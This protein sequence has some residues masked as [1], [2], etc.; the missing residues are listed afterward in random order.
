MFAKSLVIGS[1]LAATLAL[2]ATG[3]AQVTS[4]WTGAF[5]NEVGIA[6]NWT[7]ILPGPTNDVMR[8]DGT[9]SGTLFLVYA[10][11]TLG[12]AAGNVGLN[13]LLASTQTDAVNI[14]SGTTASFRLNNIAVAGGAGALT[15][16]GGGSTFNITSGGGAGT[17]FWTN[18]S[19]NAVT[20]GANIVLGTGSAAARDIFLGGS[21]NF[22]FSNSFTLSNAGS[23]GVIKDGSGT[24]TL[25]H[26]N[27]F[28]RRSLTVLGGT[29][30]LSGM[31]TN[32]NVGA[33][34]IA[35]IVGTNSGAIPVFNLN[36]GT[37]SLIAGNSSSVLIGNNMANSQ[38][39][40]NQNGGLVRL[41]GSLF[42]GQAAASTNNYAF[43]NMNGGEFNLTGVN[44]FR[45]G[46][47][48]GTGSVALLYLNAGSMSSG[49][50]VALND[51]AGGTA[52]FGGAAGLYVPAG[53]LTVT[54]ATQPMGI[55][56]RQGRSEV[57]IAGSGYVNVTTNTILGGS[58]A[59]TPAAGD[60]GRVAVLNLGAGS[61]GGTL[62]TRG[63]SQDAN[64]SPLG[65]LN[66]HGGT[67]KAQ[68]D[69]P[70]FITGLT[71]ATI[72][73]GGAKIDDNGFAVTIPQP[74]TAPAGSG[75]VSIAV[76]GASGYTGAPYVQLTGG[77]A[78]TPATAVALLNS[79]G[80]VT[81]VVVTA[82]GTGYTGAPT[83]TL[84]G[85]GGTYTS[86]TATI[87]ANTSG[88]LTK[89][90]S[91][92]LTL[93]GTNTYTG[94]TFVNTG[95]L[96][97]SNAILTGLATIDAG[98][99]LSG[100]GTINGAVFLNSGNARI[101][102]SN[103]APDTITIGGGLTLNNNNVLSYDIGSA[104]N[105]D[106]IALSGGS[107]TPNGVTTIN[108]SAIGGFGAGNRSLITG[109]GLSST[110]GFVLGAVPD[111]TFVYTLTNS[112]GNLLVRITTTNA[113]EVAF[114]RGSADNL[115]T[116]LANWSTDAAGTNTTA[117]VPSAP[118]EVTFSTVN[119]GNFNT[120]LGAD[121]EINTLTVST[122]S[123]VTIGGA[124]TL[125]IGGGLFVNPGA[126]TVTLNTGGIGLSFSQLWSNNSANALIV[127]AP[128]SGAGNALTIAGSGRTTLAG[129]NSY[130][131]G[132]I[133]NGGTLTL[134]ASDVLADTGPVTLNGAVLDIGANNDTV[135]PVTMTSG[136]I[137]GSGG[138]LSGSSYTVQTGTIS[139]RL[140][141]SGGLTKT[142]SGTLTMTGANTYTGNTHVEGGTLVLDTGCVISNTAYS[143]TGRLTGQTGTMTAQGNAM[144][145]TGSDLNFG[146][147]GNSAGT[148]NISGSAFI[149]ANAMF[150][151]SANEAG[152][153]ASGLVNQ[154]G[155]AVETRSTGL[156]TFVLGGRNSASSLGAGVYN[157]NAGTLTLR[158]GSAWIGGYGRGTFNFSGGT[159]NAGNFVAVGRQ[160]SGTGTW[161]FTGGAYLQTSG[162][163]WT[164]IGDAGVGT[165]TISN[166]ASLTTL[167]SGGLR[168]GG[169]ATASGTVN[170]DGGTILTTNVNTTGG[171]SVFH[172]NGGTLKALGP[173][174][175]FM[176][177]LSTVTVKS[178][179]AVIDDSGFEIAI[180][181]SLL[182]A[183]GGL[184]KLGNG[185]LTLSGSNTY[186][187]VTTVNAGALI[188][189]STQTTTGAVTVASGAA[190][191]VSASGASQFLPGSITLNGAA[192]EFDNVFDTNQPPAVTG[193]LV[194]NGSNTAGVVGGSFVNGG[195]YPLLTRSALS[196]AG[197]Y[198]LGARPGGVIG[199]LSTVGNTIFFNVSQVG[200]QIWKGNV[201]NN[202]DVRAT[203]N[204]TVNATP[205][206]FGNGGLVQLDDTASAF[207][208]NLASNV[209]PS[210]VLIS[211][212]TT[213]TMGGAGAIGGL[214]GLTKTGSGLVTMGTTNTYAGNTA[215]ETGTFRL[216]GDNVIP[217]GAGRGDLT[218][219]GTLDLFGRS[220]LVNGLSG[221]GTLNTTAGGA[222]VLV[223]GANGASGVFSGVVQNSAG[224]L[225]LVK[226][227]AGALTLSGAN[228]HAG[229]TV[230]QAG[231]L[232]LN[233][234]TALGAGSGTFT[235]LGGTLDVTVSN[236]ITV[237]NN[238][239]QE[240]S[241]NFTYAG[242][243][244]NLHLGTG[245]VSLG[246]S[247]G[248]TVTVNA[249]NLTVGGVISGGGAS[250]TKAGAGTLT[251]L[252]NNDF[253]GNA[254]IA[255]GTLAVLTIGDTFSPGGVGAGLQ[256]NL[257]SSGNTGRLLYLGSG[258]ETFKQI[259]LAS[260]TAG[261][262]GIV[263]HAGTG[264]LKLGGDLVGTTTVSHEFRLQGSS[265]GTGEVAGLI[266]NLGASAPT[267]LTKAGTGTWIISGFNSF[268]GPV[269]IQNGTLVV[270]S[271][272]NI[273][274]T[275]V[276]LGGGT[277]INFGQGA[278]TGRLV[279]IGGG[280]TSDKIINLGAGLGTGGG[281]IEQA[282]SGLLKFTRN[283]TASGGQPHTLTLSGSTSGSG[284][285]A[286]AIVNNSAVNRTSVAKEGTG[287]WTLSATNNTYTGST[288]VNSGTLAITGDGTI[289]GSSNIVIASGATL[290]VSG[291]TGG[292]ITIVSGQILSGSGAVVGS[293][294]MADGAILSPGSSPGVLT[295][296]GNLALNN[297]TVLAYELG[298][299]SDQTVVNGNL[300]LDGV[301]NVTDS[302]GLAAGNKILIS[303]TGGLTDNGLTVGT[304][305]SGFSGSI[306][307]DLALK[308]VV[309]VIS[310]G[311]DPY[312]SWASN[313]GLSGGNAL[314]TA[315]PDGD[316]LSN[317]NEFLAGFNPTNSAAY[318][319]V[320]SLTRT[321]NDMVVTYLGAN[322]DVNGSPGPKT[323]VLEFTTG[324]GSGG[325]TN[326]FVSTGQ[327]N[328]LTGGTGLGVVTN[329]VD[330]GGATNVPSRYYRVRV[331][332]P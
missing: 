219:N 275:S 215:I 257:G 136:A 223:V 29:M 328:I 114:W 13:L 172:F 30:T 225:R 294:T 134:G 221:G 135:G 154:N 224:S 255:N 122:A 16:G 284:E 128:I 39:V 67:L 202:W 65:Y 56:G 311:A 269:N 163:I 252:G 291:H 279:Y 81:G 48:P 117:F 271:I 91:G 303:Y 240:W 72:Y 235:I 105:S 82:P 187:G 228:S 326:N 84:V 96:R 2:A 161:W 77:G 109:G 292:G 25:T 201:N 45:I 196:G 49:L 324:T 75:V 79:S 100:S 171:V 101:S 42:L 11:N 73:S 34:T 244:T 141:G 178:A 62:Q 320:I 266:A 94:A 102:L 8:W 137:I 203:T 186:S 86:A 143:S 153:S 38:G 61:T 147:L 259:F 299:A 168:L 23:L 242:S 321:G 312:T 263:E 37:I 144:F 107:V 140:G 46:Q 17:G 155:G 32:N 36:G 325:Y 93:S 239:P 4:T 74:L 288:L 236:D 80:S 276:N 156:G 10:T 270:S 63:V 322:G 245:A 68:A 181:Q 151:G 175:S 85:G 50:G 113:A 59:G 264:L 194:L 58:V 309:L 15:L 331:L 301:V 302:G 316:G 329:M 9:Q 248:R 20:L 241:G 3:R 330:V 103:G 261:N 119:A 170:L 286:G 71:Q 314:G 205:D 35:V 99:V 208:V 272:G 197:T 157:L 209:A 64:N 212:T 216:A 277:N 182:D 24:A 98:A 150:V 234:N 21:G 319:R 97:L 164:V 231:Q 127:N 238:N 18:N 283:M 211:N 95:T 5:N 159:F 308:R 148:L 51:T 89:T 210:G 305:P 220:N 243:I 204:W 33:A 6:P 188:V 112:A 230:L 173:H 87:G 92:T 213:Y 108:L 7:P 55:G 115:W 289:A 191:R 297:A 229:G 106:R 146:D 166:A 190:L 300:T 174:P 121:F 281:V 53:T 28:M 139:A 287:L 282:G 198:T 158:A 256:I 132:T 40:F 110:N 251:L 250:L 206:T 200:T 310:G 142:G 185:S 111:P 246:A 317:T 180:G 265:T 226:T 183:G 116:T 78:T 296:N 327:T 41:T 218:V 258:E 315:D 285:F 307:N 253:S 193:T 149:S 118:T 304:M 69:N 138:L 152:S 177:G 19:A 133:V 192:I 227:G 278:N 195:S 31:F 160:A 295:V 130:D 169:A 22:V 44:R 104:P 162:S 165:L 124:N 318:L 1:V 66:F 26:T 27:N 189:P 306:S 126:G 260:A 57:T 76:S 214:G 273:G 12:G 217:G 267:T 167:A 298:T 179:G 131:G 120:T 129:A 43:Y 184:T 199:N 293:I 280:E 145:Y 249:N 88:G 176:T 254:T 60:A 70:A 232:N 207:A 125:T 83:V 262:T 332:T 274:D 90:G 268:T 313:Y 54:S 222:A 123:N 14:D 323:N 47:S 247:V 233:H 237:A 290:D 52:G